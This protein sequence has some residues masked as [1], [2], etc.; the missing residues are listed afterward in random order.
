M[1][2][3]SSCSSSNTPPPAPPSTALNPGQPLHTRATRWAPE[4]LPLAKGRL[5]AAYSTGDGEQE[6][7]Q[8][9]LELANGGMRW[10]NSVMPQI[11]IVSEIKGASHGSGSKESACNAGDV[12]LI[13]GSGRSPG[14][15]NGYHSSI[16]AWRIP[17][18]EEPSGL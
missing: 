16:L 2:T 3:H 8:L 4:I 13:P 15:G 1:H 11:F 17:W 9:D 14:E 12:S 6:G 5:H 18:T 7:V 10:G